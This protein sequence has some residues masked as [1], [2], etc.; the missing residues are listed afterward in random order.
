VSRGKALDAKQMSGLERLLF[1]A[2]EYPGETPSIDASADPEQALA[3][4]MDSDRFRAAL[5]RIA[6]AYD[7]GHLM[8]D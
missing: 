3:T 4:L 5:G 2:A 6:S 7:G 8:E 1:G